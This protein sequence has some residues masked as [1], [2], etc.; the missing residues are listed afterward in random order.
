[1][2]ITAGALKVEA[3]RLERE[4]ERLSSR[5]VITNTSI[6]E[7]YALR[8]NHLNEKTSLIIEALH[9]IMTEKESGQ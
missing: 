8:F 6:G 5:E 7:M 3:Q 9:A 1:M 2:T 4:A